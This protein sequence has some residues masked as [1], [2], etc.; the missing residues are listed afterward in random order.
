MNGTNQ[1]LKHMSLFLVLAF[2]F[3]TGSVIGWSIEVIYRRF[4]PLKGT[5]KKWVNPGFLSGPYLPI[6]GFSLIVLFLLSQV[7]V[8]FIQ[9]TKVQKLVLFCIMAVAIT[10]FEYIAGLIFIKGMKIMLWDYR[11]Q[12]GNIQGIICPIY[13]FF[14][15][16]LS[17]V[18][19]FLI[20]P[21]IESW[22]YWFTE[23][24]TFSFVI[25]F[26]YGLFTIDLCH[27][28]N[29]MTKIRKFAKE[30]QVIFRIENYKNH[31][32]QKQEE[33]KEKIR[34]FLS[35]KAEKNLPESLKE[36]LDKV[37]SNR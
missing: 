7:D 29:V 37:R 26:F 14:W 31:L 8:S 22:L 2:L 6:Y 34:Y 10:F 4:S 12:W 35:Y 23:H 24:L 3:C 27:S 18:Y 16:I 36:Y 11:G 9:N 19:Y 32:R 13:S 1:Y 20:H 5:E 33:R 28:F 21:K 17:A 30:N 25:G 15:W